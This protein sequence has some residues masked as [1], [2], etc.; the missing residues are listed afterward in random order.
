[1]FLDRDVVVD[2][3]PGTILT[4]KNHGDHRCSKVW[5]LLKW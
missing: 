2:V 4:Q 1:M 5:Y 3:D